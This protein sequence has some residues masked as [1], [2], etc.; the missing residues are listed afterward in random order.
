MPALRD[1]RLRLRRTP[2]GIRLAVLTAALAALVVCSA[3]AA[4][5]IQVRAS[6]HRL[7][8]DE[9]SRNQRALVSLQRENQRRLV[10]AATLLAE[11]PSLRS[12]IAT[13]RV[14]HDASRVVRADL[15]NTVRRELEQAGQDLD[16]GA[17][18][19]TDEKGQ[20]FAGYVR[21][22]TRLPT[23][24]DISSLSAVRNALDPEFT[25]T[26][27]E[28]Y[29]SGLELGDAFYA[30]GVAPVILDG[31]TI[32]TLVFGQ[33]VDSTLVATLRANF[34]GAVVASAG[35]HVILG[36]LPA[37]ETAA[38]LAARPA[39][40]ASITLGRAEYLA[41]TIPMGTTQHGS[42]I[43]LT[44]LQPLT[45][46]IDALATALGRDFLLYGALAVL[47]AALGAFVLSRSLLGPLGAFIS[48]LRSGAG[49][50]RPAVRF[51][52]SDASLEIR[53]LSDS[54]TQ[55]MDALERERAALESRGTELAAANAVLTDEI[56]EREQVE[57]ALRESEAQLRQS[58]KLEAVGTLAGGIAH[59]FNNLLTVISGFTQI[60][61]QRI[62]KEHEAA[63]DLKEV[64]DAAM[65]AASLTHQLLAFSRKQV[66]QPQVLDLHATVTGMEGMLRRLIG[67]HIDLRV[68]D[69]GSP[70]RV[71]ADP[72]QLEQVLLNLV[73]NAR[74]AMPKGG[75]IVIATR[76]V[77]DASGAP[78]VTLRVTDSGIGMPPDVRDRIFEPFYT[79][80]EPGKGTGLGLA[81]VYGIVA[82]SGGT[83]AV[84]SQLGQG[85]TFT[86]SLP[87]AVEQATPLSGEPEAAV[88][89]RGT[90]TILL[91]D[92]DDA[93]RRM[94]ERVLTSLGYTVVVARDGID[95][96]THA[97]ALP[98][99]D[100]LL[101]D[102]VMPQLSGP[103]VAERLRRRHPTARV[104]YMTGWVDDAIMKLELDTDVA[105]LRK[106][107]TPVGLGRLIR[108]ALDQRYS[109]TATHA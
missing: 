68:E 49:A 70:A 109:P 50:D 23:G 102:V 18:L 10:L 80:K 88:A 39:T 14:E 46:T 101:T 100:V 92:D 67:S 85:T 75:A 36:T 26:H 44:L 79:T 38:L 28:S 65:R 71:K 62:G 91:V 69:D 4:L 16:A 15:T 7:L 94:A 107:F 57:R 90:E 58:Q 41:A 64:S 31:Y 59:D 76:H 87:S 17:L 33:R 81:T 77:R 1:L 20:V 99:V 42:D 63:P 83:I 61:A 30:V 103:Q 37:A 82:Q 27:G 22:A 97:R 45:P 53:T 29:L 96:L 54:F 35:N 2:L 6:T 86:I 74:D 72:G 48:A 55:L 32:G 104:V 60:A 21:G 84:A 93:I 43:T 12:A 19:A 73:I 40:G 95:A 34:D 106:P 13:Y 47:L 3:F 78:R 24:L 108:S 25:S 89:P 9:L 51:D 11:S 56:R 8:A 66:L 52:A 98:R 105:L 5:S